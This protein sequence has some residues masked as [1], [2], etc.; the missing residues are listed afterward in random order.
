VDY[1]VKPVEG[2][3]GEYGAHFWLNAGGLYPDVPRD[4]FSAN[5]FQGQHVFII[6]SKDLVVVRLGLVE[7]P[8][9]NINTFLR[10]VIKAVDSSAE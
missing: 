2:S 4:L 1:T 3:N 10:E 5:G 8:D 7:H 6:P 9:F